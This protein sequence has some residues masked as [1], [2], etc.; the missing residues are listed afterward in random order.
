[1]QIFARLLATGYVESVNNIMEKG[2]NE[3]PSLN[4][5]DTSKMI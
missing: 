2:V 3:F 1:M 5:Q 4:V